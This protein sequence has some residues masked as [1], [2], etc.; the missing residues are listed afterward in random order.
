MGR[1]VVVVPRRAALNPSA[2]RLWIDV[3]TAH[4]RQVDHDAAFGHRLAGHV[5][6]ATAH[7]DLESLRSSEAN[8]IS[9]VDRVDASGNHRG[10]LVDHSVVYRSGLVI[11]RIRWDE[12]RPGKLTA[13]RADNVV[14]QCGTHRHPPLA[15]DPSRIWSDDMPCDQSAKGAAT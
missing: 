6:P 15:L 12:H 1:P 5:V 13:Q 4:L 14:R 8:R 7:R 2:S 9:N 11:T 10:S 3:S